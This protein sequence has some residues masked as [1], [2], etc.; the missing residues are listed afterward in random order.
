M[1]K[2]MQFDPFQPSPRGALSVSF[3]NRKV[4]RLS[5][6]ASLAFAAALAGAQVAPSHQDASLSSNKSVLPGGMGS[7]VGHKPNSSESKNLIDK[8][9]HRS[10]GYIENKGQWPSDVKFMG[11]SN[12]MDL[13]VTNEGL[14]INAFKK[15]PGALVG[16][17]VGIQFEGGKVLASNGSGLVGVR[18]DFLQA[19]HIAKGAQTFTDVNSKN[20]YP[21]I[22][23]KNY[24]DGS[25]PRY[26]FVVNPRGKPSAIRM[27]YIASYGL[28]VSP[29]TVGIKT[30]IGTIVENKLAAYQMIGGKKKPVSVAFRELAKN[31]VGFKV[32]AYD[33]SKQLIIDPVL[34]YGS[35]YGGDDGMD[36]VHAVTSD[37]LGGV[38]MTGNTMS[39]DFPRIFGP[40]SLSL[41][42]VQDAFVSKLE[43]D[44]YVHD[45]AAYLG[46]SQ[47]DSGEFLQLD[48]FGDLWVAGYTTSPDFPGLN[49]DNIQYITLDQV[50]SEERDNNGLLE[51]PFGLSN[52]AAHYRVLLPQSGLFSGNIPWD[53]SP[54]TTQSIVQTYL[55]TFAPGQTITV[56]DVSGTGHI[57][58]GRGFKF[59]FSPGIVGTMKIDSNFLGAVYSGTRK[60]DGRMQ[61]IGV[62]ATPP[63]TGAFTLSVAYTRAGNFVGQ[64]NPLAFNAS[65]TAVQAALN[66]LNPDPS[67]PNQTKVNVGAVVV[68]GTQ[69]TSASG[70]ATLPGQGLIVKFPGAESPMSVNIGTMDQ[71]YGDVSLFYDLFFWDPTSSFPSGGVPPLPGTAPDPNPDGD[72]WNLAYGTSW[73]PIIR[74]FTNAQQLHDAIGASPVGGGNVVV[75]PETTGALQMPGTRMI[76]SYTGTLLGTQPLGTQTSDDPVFSGSLLSNVEPKVISDGRTNPRPVY[77][78]HAE[79]LCFVI[80]FK[81]DNNTILNPLPTRAYFFG[82]QVAPVLGSFRIIPHSNPVTGEPI[83]MAFGGTAEDSSELLPQISTPPRSAGLAAAG[84]ILRV[85]YT[86]GNGQF[87]VD[88]SSQYVDAFD[89]VN[90]I[91]YDVTMGGLDV[92]SSGNV[93]V[94]GTIFTSLGTTI[95][96]SQP[97]ANSD[98]IFQTTPVDPNGTLNSGRLLRFDDGYVRKYSANGTMQYSVLIGG[99]GADFGYGVAVDGNGDAYL[100]GISESFN[101]PRTRGVYGEVFTSDAVTTIAKLNPTA[102]D[103]IYCTHLHTGGIVTPIGIQVDSRGLAYATVELNRGTI[104]GP[105]T[106]LNDPN[107]P[108]GFEFV[109]TIP[110]TADAIVPDSGA[111]QY[112]GG[113]GGG[114]DGSIEGGLL[115]LNPSATGLVYGTLLGGKLDAQVFPPF[116]DSGGDVW[117]CGWTDTLRHYFRD[118]RW[119]PTTRI[120]LVKAALPGSMIS[121]LAFR[122]VPD[123][124]NGVVGV[125]TT[126]VKNVLY[127]T[128]LDNFPLYWDEAKERDGWVDRLRIGLAAVASVGFAP[129]TIPGGLGASSTGTVTLSQAAPA[130]GA[131]IALT[132]P[133]NSPASFSPNS[134]VTAETITIAAGA[135][136]G[137]FVVYSSSVSDTTPVDVT[138]TY[139]GSFHVGR[140]VIVPWLQSFSITPNEVVGGNQAI[141]RIQLAG[142]AGA[143]GVTVQMSSDT[144]SVIGIQN[145]TVPNGQS[146]VSFNI[147]TAGVDTTTTVTVNASLLGVGKPF[148]LIVDPAQLKS[149][150]FN[151]NPVSSGST[152]TGTLVLNG[153]PGPSGIIADL[154]VEGS[155]AGY[156]LTPT[157][158]TFAG[159][160][161]P[162][163]S[164]TFT[165][166]TPYEAATVNRTVDA[167]MEPAAGHPVNT[168]KGTLNVVADAVT[169]FSIAPNPVNGGATASATVTLAT[170]ALVGG[171]KVDIAVSPDN[172]TVQVP[173]SIIVPAGQTSFVF[174]VPTTTT[175]AN[176]NFTVT[177]SRG[178]SSKSV[179]LTVNKLTF[180]VSVPALIASGSTVSG[181]ITLSGKA[182][183]GGIA[184]N[185]SSSLPGVLTVPSV[186][187]IPAGQSSVVFT[188]NALAVLTDTD[189]TISATI[190]ATTNTADTTV[191]ASKLVGMT[192]MPGYVLNLQTVRCTLTLDGPAPAG[193]LPIT[194]TNTNNAVA[195]VPASVT[196]PAGQTSITFSFA[197]RRVTRTLMTTIT[198]F[199]GNGGQA[200]SALIV[201]N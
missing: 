63:T 164:Q 6:V 82:G 50:H 23:L 88:P 97:T 196:V 146:A 172:G 19:G 68:G 1:N 40:Y 145:I 12:G 154:L 9:T 190:G 87:A 71:P 182:P 94:G 178:T 73:C 16:H 36:E 176:S 125:G 123:P 174:Q 29:Q 56:T 119:A 188:L 91:G 90:D 51:Q 33:H 155:P 13:W 134:S 77:V 80:R 100:L 5:F 110:T 149:L 22:D 153:N 30:S 115:V 47:S 46:G 184:V 86:D 89:S 193:G 81:Q 45:Y 32:G 168:V 151:P 37:L 17:V 177:A 159:G 186:V 105:W 92:D 2:A 180:T 58:N 53:A 144:P 173:K 99:D 108:S 70:A 96:T 35:Y 104:I 147:N 38:Y 103:L 129:A 43:G 183:P 201:H 158:L 152:S 137:T 121:P 141:G 109:G 64:T 66:N 15:S 199:S 106:P 130:G 54:A 170:A 84:F 75:I 112:T 34:V 198:A 165:V 52:G 169:S 18:T 142:N 118:A 59:D 55:N 62:V 7:T 131:T 116:V 41:N 160:A 8:M 61:F 4:F 138:A 102:T 20:L 93:Y 156:V 78:A 57:Y 31:T 185:L 179:I 187:S 181:T 133:S 67:D 120:F 127:N 111:T 175:I 135:T 49:A 197:T 163:T 161:S 117:V 126:L 21:G 128:E 132:I 26:D 124:D 65:G 139:E 189:V 192:L 76:A 191:H 157:K 136:T 95:D 28:A 171:A 107:V 150:T 122:P 167:T 3:V 72:T 200:S 162:Q 114:D 98:F 166:A 83:R 60:H 48:Q 25:Q 14:R 24:F 148:A 85:N 69:G 113:P 74:Y 195:M 101:Y 27:K 11:R 194:V 79:N 39:T 44:A 42:G 140:V 10:R 143:L